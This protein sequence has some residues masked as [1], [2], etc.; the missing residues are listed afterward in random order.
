MLI[1]AKHNDVHCSTTIY[2]IDNQ[3][4]PTIEHRELYN[5]L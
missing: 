2:E 3:P 5:I 1:V 4:G